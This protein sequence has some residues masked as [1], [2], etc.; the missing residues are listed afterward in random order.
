MSLLSKLE[1]LVSGHKRRRR[2]K[3][4][5]RRAK[6]EHKPKAKSK[7][8]PKALREYWEKKRKRS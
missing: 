8:M 1:S 5:A 4:K 7:R 3:P 2:S 6:K